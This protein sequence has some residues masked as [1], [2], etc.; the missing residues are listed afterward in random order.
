MRERGKREGRG[1]EEGEAGGQHGTH[2]CES[3]VRPEPCVRELSWP[4]PVPVVPVLQGNEQLVKSQLIMLREGE[5]KGSG[6]TH[7]W[8]VSW[9]RPVPAVPVVL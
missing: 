8:V 1:R 6:G 4:S 9:P 3:P 5:R 7:W 2:W